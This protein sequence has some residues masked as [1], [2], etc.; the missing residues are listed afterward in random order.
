MGRTLQAWGARVAGILAALLM[1]TGA[2]AAQERLSGDYY[3]LD[4]ARGLTI[5]LQDG[6]AGAT[7]RI[8]AG[9]G[10]GQAIDGRR[11][12]GAI[13]SKLIFQGKQ[14]T[15]RFVPQGLGLGFEWTADDGTGS[16]VYAFGR[17]GLE[18]PPP[19]PSYVPED[20]IG[21]RVEPHVFVASYEFWQPE[22]VARTY[23]AM[24]DKFRAILQFFPAVQTDI[25]WKLCQSTTAARGLGEALRG[26]GVTCAQV[27]TTLKNAQRS[28]GFNAFKRRVHAERADA[29]RAVQCARGIHPAEVCAASARRTQAA[30]ISLETVMTVLRGI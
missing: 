20:R 27:D 9:D 6:G 22:T 7:G 16:V 30:A 29:E 21:S 25:L 10:S 17:R 14:G 24:D 2:A 26:E 1:L 3:G 13:V 28:G 8:A 19:S 23:D 4:E 12:G 5:R 15:A 18:L 11:Q